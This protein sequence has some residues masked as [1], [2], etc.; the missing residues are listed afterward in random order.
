MRPTTC[1]ATRA[2][3]RRAMPGDAIIDDPIFVSD[4]AITIAAPVPAVWPWLV[5]MGAGRAGW[6]S[7]DL[8]DNG[9][10]PS[11]TQILPVYQH[12]AVGDILPAIPGASDAFRVTAVEPQ[13]DL[14]LTVPDGRGGHRVTWEHR[15]EPLEGGRTRLL[16]R[17]RVARDWLAPAPAGALPPTPPIF[18]E[19]IYALMARMPRPILL[20]FAGLGHR[21]M[22]A[23][24]LRGIKRRAEQE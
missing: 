14:L 9:G 5:Q 2:E 24:H 7:W 8:I 16:V 1:L 6:Y 23:R 15:L 13:R 20:A 10:R 17:G 3:R 12:V 22:E 11:S 19:R 21:V 18:I 4:H